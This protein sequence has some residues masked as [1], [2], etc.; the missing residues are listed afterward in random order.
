MSLSV[1][2]VSRVASLVEEFVAQSQHFF[3]SSSG[4]RSAA[5]SGNKL[6]MKDL[7]DFDA[8]IF[9]QGLMYKFF[10]F[11]VQ[12]REISFWSLRAH[13]QIPIYLENVFCEIC[14]SHVFI[15]GV[16][17]K[18]LRL[19]IYELPAPPGVSQFGKGNHPKMLNKHYPSTY[20]LT[21]C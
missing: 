18:K 16:S 1:V 11:F 19:L 2:K 10:Y 15:Q 20:F 14:C 8:F 17:C 5:M 4:S 9:F 12:K 7:R 6:K 3:P 21:I 13:D